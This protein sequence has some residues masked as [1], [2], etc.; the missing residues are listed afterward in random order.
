M[1]RVYRVSRVRVRVSCHMGALATTLCSIKS[2][3]RGDM[4]LPLSNLTAFQKL[5]LA[6][7]PVNLL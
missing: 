4:V 2:H 3:S 5:F 1:V 6:H 7:S